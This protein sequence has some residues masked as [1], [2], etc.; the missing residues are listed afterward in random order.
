MVGSTFLTSWLFLCF[1]LCLVLCSPVH[2]QSSST[3]KESHPPP[4]RWTCVGRA[5]PNHVVDLQIGLK[6]DDYES[7]ERYLI[8]GIITTMS[9]ASHSQN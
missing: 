8:K 2:F 7:L 9:S 4:P 5:D 3:L 6:Q 1:A